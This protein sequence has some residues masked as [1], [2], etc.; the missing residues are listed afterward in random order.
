MKRNSSE[1]KKKK[2]ERKKYQQKGVKD[3]KE[4]LKYLKNS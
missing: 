1:K 4:N 3:E 2:Y